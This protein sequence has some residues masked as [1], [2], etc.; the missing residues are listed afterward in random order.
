MAKGLALPGR[1]NGMLWDN[2][3]QH[4]YFYYKCH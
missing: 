4:R 2:V 1:A 3:I